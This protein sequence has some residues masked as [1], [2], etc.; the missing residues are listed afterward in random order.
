MTTFKGIDRL[1]AIG[2]MLEIQ[3]IARFPDAKKL[4]AFFGLNPIW[5]Q[6]GDG[7]TQ[8]R[9]SKK[10]RK[11]PRRLLF[12][13]ALNA[14]RFNPLIKEVYERHV[15]NGMPKLAAV[16]VCMNKIA[17]ILYGMRKHKKPFDPA[18]DQANQTKSVPVKA[19]TPVEDKNRRFQ[20]PDETAPI[21]ARQAK[22]RALHTPA[23][24]VEAGSPATVT[25]QLEAIATDPKEAPASQPMVKKSLA[26]AN[27]PAKKQP[28]VT[29]PVVPKT[30]P[31]ALLL[32][33]GSIEN[34]PVTAMP[35]ATP[36]T[37]LGQEKQPAKNA[38]VEENE[39]T[40]IMA[41]IHQILA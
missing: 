31:A 40:K 22:K 12:M 5:E 15:K 19:K 4:A 14:I 20:A 41:S 26:M 30:T 24:P 33:P 39:K 17:R 13:V 37:P 21:S 28:Q 9:M 25:Q 8:T 6:S 10:G 23:V 7:T 18:I 34:Q 3:S 32:E 35:V 16:G 29:P 1:A 38:P 36:S 11:A 2:L 27:R